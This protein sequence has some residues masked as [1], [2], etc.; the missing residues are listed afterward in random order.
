MKANAKKKTF[1]IIMIVLIAVIVGCG[2]MAVGNLKGWFGGNSESPLV[3][4]AVTGVANM[5]RSSVAYTL[6]ENVPMQAGDL[7]ETK[8]DSEAEFS[9]D[10]AGTL[11]LGNKTEI[12]IE[13]CRQ[14][15]IKST[16]DKGEIFADMAKA[17]DGVAISFGSYNA[18]PSE[19]VFSLSV[20]EG[21]AVLNVYKGEVNVDTGNGKTGIKAG[22]SLIV[23]SDTNGKQTD[24]IEN[25]EAA[26]LNEFQISK[27]QN[28]SERTCFTSAR[29][30]KVIKDRK[31]EKEKQAKALQQEALAVVSSESSKD[32]SGGS[33]ANV[34]TCTIQIQCK[35]I[36]SNMDKLKEG[37]NRYVPS[38]G[39][40]LATS[41]VEFNKGESAYDVTRRAC[42]AAGIQMEAAYT[43]VYS[44]Y[45]VEGMNNLYEFDCGQS[46]GWM[47]K[48]NGWPPNYGCSEYTL[49]NGDSIVWYYTC[50]GN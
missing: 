50:S 13:T 27:L 24:D 7:I 18:K 25:I 9:A 34:M 11:T 1:N 10:G 46:S 8:N 48:V 39:V 33:G 26:S 4:G 35:S 40:V 31:A 5:E 6:D 29:L 15:N 20:Q 38:N 41:K 47:Y 30:E 19:A 14:G 42:N 37:K 21:S 32:G 36:L 43:P 44:G 22:R 45:Y 28:C 49:K 3:S 16:V 17:S 2:I 12:S 23:S